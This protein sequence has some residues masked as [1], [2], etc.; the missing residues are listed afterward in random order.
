MIQ[1][2]MNSVANQIHTFGPYISFN[3]MYK[4]KYYHKKQFFLDLISPQ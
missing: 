4:S 2:A 1:L 3:L